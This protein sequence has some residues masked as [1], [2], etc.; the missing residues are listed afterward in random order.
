[1]FISVVTGVALAAS[2]LG[3]GGAAHA[4]GVKPRIQG[5]A[6]DQRGHLLDDVT[7]K[8]KSGNTVVA[9]ALTYANQAADGPQ[10]GYF[11]LEVTKGTYSLTLSKK[12]YKTVEYDAGT[13]SKR[14][15]K[16]SMGELVI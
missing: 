10:H 5:T 9:S 14:G 8:A 4:A 11:Y 7:V 3:V 13:I 2:A 12:G 6:V 1:M 16:I 15:Q